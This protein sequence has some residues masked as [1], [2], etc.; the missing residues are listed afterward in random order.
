MSDRTR[1]VL[2]NKSA[3]KV[4]LI[5]YRMQSCMAS[6]SHCCCHCCLRHECAS[7]LPA[8]ITFIQQ[9]SIILCQ[10]HDPATPHLLD[11][12]GV[13]LT[14]IQYPKLH[15]HHMLADLELHL[16]FCLITRSLLSNKKAGNGGLLRLATT[17]MPAS[18]KTPV[19]HSQLKNRK[20]KKKLR[21]RRQ[22]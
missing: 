4:S 10:L 3:K 22:A 11:S 20:E 9:C 13:S 16:C 1:T 19:L 6:L 12:P 15:L 7:Q 8:T 18:C 14:I 2:T 21:I 17:F 5:L